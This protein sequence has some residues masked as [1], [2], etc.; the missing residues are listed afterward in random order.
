[1]DIISNSSSTANSFVSFLRYHHFSSSLVRSA[2]NDYIGESA[3]ME[4]GSK[5]ARGTRDGDGV[6]G[7]NENRRLLIQ[8]VTQDEFLMQPFVG[9]SYLKT[10]NAVILVC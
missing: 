10:H 1:M 8:R 6:G 9:F 3:R 4:L 7:E 5:V 2:Q